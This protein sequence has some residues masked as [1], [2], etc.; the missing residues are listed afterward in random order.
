MCAHIGPNAGRIIARWDRTLVAD[1]LYALCMHH[2]NFR[3][4]THTGELILEQPKVPHNP[5]A[6]M[7]NGHRADFHRIFYD[8]A[9]SLGIT[10]HMGKRIASYHEDKRAGNAWVATDSGE[11]FCGNV[12]VG[13]DGVRSQAR[14]L[15]LGLD[16]R[17]QSSGYAVYRA[18]FNAEA[19]GIFDDDLTR[20]FVANGDT[21]T[22]CE[23][24]AAIIRFC[25][26]PH[27]NLPCL[28]KHLDS[29]LERNFFGYGLT[30]ICLGLGPDVHFLVA[31][32]KEGRDLSWVC[33]H[34]VSYFFYFFDKN[35]LKLQWRREG[36]GDFEG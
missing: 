21:H 4:H 10:I 27:P 23:Y 24:C 31:S 19:A 13:A 14:K 36:G 25:L 33:T 5:D 18:W 16:D 6:P 35:Y 15:V 12:V 9:L 20:E 34:R 3:I 28:F 26:K 2:K 22:G 1:R 8:Y 32:C 29:T 11:R 30:L 7:Y 17:T